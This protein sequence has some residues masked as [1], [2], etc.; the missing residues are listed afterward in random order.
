MISIPSIALNLFSLTTKSNEFFS[1][2]IFSVEFTVNYFLLHKTSSPLGFYSLWSY[3]LSVGVP[4]ILSWASSS[5]FNVGPSMQVPI[6]LYAHKY[7]SLPSIDSQIIC[8][9]HLL[10]NLVVPSVF[11]NSHISTWMYHLLLGFPNKWPSVTYAR[12]WTSSLNP[13]FPSL[14]TRNQLASSPTQLL[15]F[16][17]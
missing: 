17:T 11:W 9:P 4:L 14:P 6:F 5:H 15:N 7:F 8:T 1:V 10:I 3:L 12:I 16:S 2:F 13:L